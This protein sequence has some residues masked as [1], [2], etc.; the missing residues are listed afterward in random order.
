[1]AAGYGALRPTCVNLRGIMIKE[2]NS[3]AQQASEKSS[4]GNSFSPLSHRRLWRYGP[5]VVWAALIFIGSTDIL[6]GSN[7]NPFL[8]PLLVSV[9]PHASEST[10][11]FLI[12]AVRKAGHLTEYA[13]LALLAARAI[14]SSSRRFL[15]LHWFAGSILFV[16]LY[17]SS[18]EFHQSFVPTRGASIYDVLIDTVGGMIGLL[19]FWVWQRR[20]KETH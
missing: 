9:F 12:F 4:L 16:A 7:T 8:K 17:A 2:A 15:S 14:H 13:F 20:H 5:V 19:I 10:L 3:V 1:M 11:A 6:S 18:D